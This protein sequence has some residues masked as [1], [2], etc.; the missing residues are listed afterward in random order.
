MT[1]EFLLDENVLGLDRF[2]KHRVNYRMVGDVDCPAKEAD[3][4]EIV[5]FARE[6]GLVIVTKDSKMVEQCEFEGVKYVTFT[7]IDFAKKVTEY[8]GAK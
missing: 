5:K 4:P 2:L 7:D 8:P 6:N 3:D 1:V